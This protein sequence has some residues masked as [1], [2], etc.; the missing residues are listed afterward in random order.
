[1]IENI[2]VKM[3]DPSLSR[4]I[5]DAYREIGTIVEEKNYLILEVGA[6]TAD[7]RIDIMRNWTYLFE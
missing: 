4:A 6:A 5:E 7:E 2:L 3:Y 1:M